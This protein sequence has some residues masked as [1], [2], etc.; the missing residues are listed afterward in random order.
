MGLMLAFMFLGNMLGALIIVPAL[1]TYLLRSEPVVP[2]DSGKTESDS[3][4]VAE[5][6]SQKSAA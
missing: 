3:D 1:A 2:H 6:A 5:V 4:S